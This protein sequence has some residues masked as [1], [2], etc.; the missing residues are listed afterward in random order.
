[1]KAY[2][3]ALM[4]CLGAAFLSGAATDG[5]A[6][7]AYEGKTL[8]FIINFGIG[9]P[10]DTF[11]RAFVPHLQRHLPG[12]P[13]IVVENRPGAAGRTGA[14]YLYNIAKP[15]G[16]TIGGMVGVVNDA[17]FGLPSKYDP[18]KFTWL[19]AVPQTQVTIVRSELGIRSPSDLVKTSKPIL[20]AATGQNSNNY[21]ATSLALGMMKV[22]FKAVHGYVGQSATIHALRQGEANLT[23][24]GGPFYLPNK[25]T[26]AK[27]GLLPVLQRGDL[28]PNGE[29]KR[30]PL[31]PDVPTMPEAIAQLHPDALKSTEYV[32]YRLIAGTYALQYS[33]V[34]PPGVAPDIA[35]VLRKAVESA[36]TDPVAVADVKK[37]MNLE[38][39]FVTGE[40]AMRTLHSLEAT[41]REHPKARKMLEALAT[42][43]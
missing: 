25:D 37:Q 19:G 33:I 15:D 18:E 31:I 27:D 14:A 43:K 13:T 40:E 5:F 21:I 12:N 22:P 29:F 32:A 20:M 11:F 36:L 35:A 26:W 8:R 16:L 23:D 42:V 39:N 4:A 30:S 10:L 17:V 3:S 24:A 1:M 6:Q 7:P 9:G 2:R 34:A 38:F 41:A 28:Q